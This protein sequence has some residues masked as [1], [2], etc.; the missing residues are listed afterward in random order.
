MG[1]AQ[2]L[3]RS[4]TRSPPPSATAAQWGFVETVFGKGLALWGAVTTTFS[5]GLACGVVAAIGS[6]GLTLWSLVIAVLQPDLSLPDDHGHL[7][8]QLGLVA[9]CRSHLVPDLFFQTIT[10][11]FSQG[12]ALWRAVEPSAAT[13]WLNTEWLDFTCGVA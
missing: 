1:L 2:A 4:I 13:V 3:L 7:Q 5:Q 12:L 10:A 8:L 9:S 11:V 6:Q